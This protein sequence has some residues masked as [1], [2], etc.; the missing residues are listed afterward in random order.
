M[1]F[2][3]VRGA[4][5]DAEIGRRT[6]YWIIY[7]V[8]DG[9][10]IDIAAAKASALMEAAETRH[11]EDVRAKLLFASFAD[12]RRESAPVDIDGLA[13]APKR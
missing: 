5:A 7:T 6:S 10:G 8:D 1:T 2:R 11:G 4:L 12:L 3:I 9:K 13:R